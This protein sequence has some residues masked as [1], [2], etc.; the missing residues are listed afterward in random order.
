M[1]KISIE[2]D[3]VAMV[4]SVYKATEDESLGL[5]LETKLKTTHPQVVEVSDGPCKGK[6]EPG[7]LVT[8]IETAKAKAKDIQ[9]NWLSAQVEE[10]SSTKPSSSSTPL[11]RTAHASRSGMPIVRRSQTTK[12]Y[13]GN[14]KGKELD[15]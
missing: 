11:D 6:I 12:Q 2:R 15:T 7:D 8:D 10:D 5:A 3:G 13:M 4:V 9:M 14:L 1:L